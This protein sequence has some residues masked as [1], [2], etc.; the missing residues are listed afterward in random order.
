VDGNLREYVVR[1]GQRTLGSVRSAQPLSHAVI[2]WSQDGLPRIEV[3][4]WHASFT[5]ALEALATLKRNNPGIGADIAPVFPADAP[6][7]P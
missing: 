6:P 7:A 2:A 1:R 5:A 4:S 3:A